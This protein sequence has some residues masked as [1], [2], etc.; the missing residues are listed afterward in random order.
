MRFRLALG[1]SAMVGTLA[2]PAAALAVPGDR[3]ISE[4]APGQF[5]L[6]ANTLEPGCFIPFRNAPVDVDSHLVIGM[7]ALTEEAH[8]TVTAGA[9][10]SVDQVLVPSPIDGYNIEG[11]YDTGTI[12]NDPDIDPG[13]TATGLKSPTRFVDQR[14]IIVCVSG[15]HGDAAQNE[16]YQEEDGGLVSAKNR[17]VITPKVTALGASAIDPLNTYKM[18]FGYDAKWHERPAFETAEDGNG[19]FASVSDPEAF[20]SPTFG[21][22]LP[23]FVRMVPRPADFSYDAR[24]V[25]DVDKNGE[26]WAFPTPD[27]DQT[28]FFR[29]AGDDTAWID[30]GGVPGRGTGL[31]TT[32]TRGDFPVSWTLRPSLASPDNLRTVEFSSK[33]FDEWEQGWQDYY[34]GKGPH[35]DLPLAPGSNSP[36]PRD[37]PVIVNP[38]EARPPATV[39]NPTPVTVVVTQAPAAVAAAPASKTA[40][41]KVASAKQKKAYKRCVKKAN[42]KHGKSHRKARA[43]CARMPH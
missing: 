13:Q 3:A 28:M 34:C 24:R 37:C 23:G 17:P 42:K 5:R 32:L 26:H 14:D 6:N 39:I 19:L 27:A 31:F 33:D 41:K 2:M 22:S 7:D 1:V 20:A 15:G 16:P 12:N 4:P 29:Q 21:D 18:G 11:P 35:P 25:N 30:D 9:P 38:P 43:K 36:D 8:V 40:A 10:F